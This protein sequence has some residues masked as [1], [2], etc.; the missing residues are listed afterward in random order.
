M[1]FRCLLLVAFCFYF[2]GGTSEQTVSLEGEA[3][4]NSILCRPLTTYQLVCAPRGLTSG[5]VPR[6]GISVTVPKP[7]SIRGQ[8]HS[9]LSGTEWQL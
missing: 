5:M 7:K 8:N 3:M 6:L 4:G 2:Y 9:Y 1:A